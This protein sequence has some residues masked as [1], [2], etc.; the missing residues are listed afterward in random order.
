MRVAGVSDL[1]FAVA[2]AILSVAALL[3]LWRVVRGPTL[4]DRVVA[5]DLLG[6]IIAGFTVIGAASTGESW[7][8]DVTIVITLVTFVGSDVWAQSPSPF[9]R[10]RSSGTS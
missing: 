3:A 9:A 10:P 8:L 2:I 1:L 4:P 7:F 6:V 5:I